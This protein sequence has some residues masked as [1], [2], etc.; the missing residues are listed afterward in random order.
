MRVIYQ[1]SRSNFFTLSFNT[2]MNQAFSKIVL[3]PGYGVS[4]TH[5]VFFCLFPLQ[6]RGILPETLLSGINLLVYD[7]CLMRT[8]PELHT[9]LLGYLGYLDAGRHDVYMETD[10]ICRAMHC[11]CKFLMQCQGEVGFVLSQN[12]TILHY[13]FP[14]RQNLDCSK[15]KEFA[16]DNFK[17]DENGRMFSKWGR[18]HCGKRGNCSL[19]AISPFPTVFQKTCTADT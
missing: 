8:T 10:K 6:C 9:V 12:L 14:K 15:L 19:R 13:P 17:F 4:Q 11:T 7:E 1:R 2:L 18:K 3:L 16:V 5:L